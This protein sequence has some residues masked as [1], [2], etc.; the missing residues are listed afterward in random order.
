MLT[1]VSMTVGGVR[2]CPLRRGGDGR[3]EE[4]AALGRHDDAAEGRGIPPPPLKE[5]FILKR[6]EF[7]PERG[8]FVRKNV[9]LLNK[10]GVFRIW[11]GFCL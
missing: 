2:G 9:S 4:M 11:H 6:N 3:C 10:L 5:C 7:T 8:F 1:S